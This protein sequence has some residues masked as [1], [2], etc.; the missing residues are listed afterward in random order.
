[1]SDLTELEKDALI[2]MFNIGVGRS[3]AALNQLVSQDVSL[4]V[5]DLN[6]IPNSEAIKRLKQ[7]NWEP[8]SAVTQM[9]QGDFS[10]QAILLFTQEGCMK[11]V[12]RL[13]GDSVPLETLS[14]LEQDSLVEIG[15]IILN[16]CFG[17]VINF[18][19]ADIVIDIPRFRQGQI[20]EIYD[21]VSK[22]DW[23]LYV[24]VNFSSP[25]DSIEGSVSF[26]M[27]FESRTIFRNAVRRFVDG[28]DAA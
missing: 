18:L 19:H 16:A 2:E 13:L 10:G 7:Q 8:V 21:H 12:R 9:F 27:D 20:E 23:S 17:T 1:M 15:N 5:P 6:L 11:L 22:G 28:I 24:E 3:A 14:E 25:N 26:I 4:N